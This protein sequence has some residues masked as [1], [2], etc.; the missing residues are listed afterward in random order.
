MYPDHIRLYID[1]KRRGNGVIEA[2]FKMPDGWTGYRVMGREMPAAMHRSMEV[3]VRMQA[4]VGLDPR[5]AGRPRTG[6]PKTDKQA[7]DTFAAAAH[8]VITDIRAEQTKTE[9]LYGKH[10]KKLDKYKKNVS[11]INSGLVP[12]FGA[13]RC[14]DI[15]ADAAFAFQIS[16]RNKDG[17][18]PSASTMGNLGALF[19]RV[20]KHSAALGWRSR[21]GIPSLSKEGLA[22]PPR[23]PDV[24]PADA[25]RLMGRMSDAWCADA[26]RETT[27]WDRTLFRAFVAVAIVT[28]SRPGTEL[29]EMKWKHVTPPTRSYPHWLFALTGKTDTREVSPDES[30]I[31][32]RDALD[33]AR[34]INGGEP[35]TL[36]FA[37][38]TGIVRHDNF[39]RYFAA[40][41]KDLKITPMHGIIP[42]SLYSIRH[43]YATHL[44]RHGFTDYQIAEVMG[45][46]PAM[47][48]KHYGHVQ[49]LETAN[50][51]AAIAK[52]MD[53]LRNRLVIEDLR[54]AD[55]PDIVWPD[56]DPDDHLTPED[57]PSY[58]RTK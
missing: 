40:L 26:T 12:H 41:T 30:L 18:R 10:S 13:M 53:K 5:P 16:Y 31:A 39:M 49:P 21:T 3:W 50:R 22:P 6:P 36:L 57:F 23:R 20:L 14:R 52:P 33:A 35:D 15:G 46:S 28:G 51:I 9:A 4:G 58:A 37:R 19:R 27:R 42:I 25:L 43:Y 11:Q 34:R 17:T 1:R 55:Q 8:Q 24:Q 29:T 45:T 54:K 32:F 2:Q 48:H 44:R 56:D 47:I 7:T 38:P